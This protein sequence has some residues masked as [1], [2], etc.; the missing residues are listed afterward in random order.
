MNSSSV[1]SEKSLKN[2]GKI[3]VIIGVTGHRR[4]REQ[5]LE[6]ITESVREQI[7][8]LRRRCPHSQ[9]IVM[10]CLAEGADQLCAEIALD[11][12]L[13]IMSVLPMPIEEYAKDFTGE[14]LDKLYE[15]AEKSLKTFVAPHIEPEQEG[16]NYLYRQAGVYVAD[17]CHLLLALW[18]GS[19]PVKG[20]CGTSSIAQLK[21][22]NLSREAGEQLRHAKG[23]VVQIKTP[24]VGSPGSVEGAGAVTV[25]GDETWF[26]RV[27]R[28][29]DIYN[30]DCEQEKPA[31]S[32][33]KLSAVYE[34]ADRMSM[35]S[36]VR[37]R[38][39]LAGMSVCAVV[40][41][42]AFLL[43][44]EVDW[45]GMIILCGIMIIMLFLI[46]TITGKSKCRERYLEYRI[47][48]EAC[49]VQSYLKMAGTTLSVAEFIPWNLQV[50]VPWI[51]RAMAAVTAGDTA[52]KRQSVLKI[53]ITDQKEYHK[54]AVLRSETQ[55]MR[56]DRIVRA[57]LIFTILIYVGALAFEI[58][59]G[60]LFGGK[61]MFSAE[62]NDV[63]R[64]IIKVA[65]GTFS[66][67]TVFTGNYYGKLALPNVIDDHLKMILLYEEAE[68]EIAEKGESEPLL[69]RIAEDELGE[70]ANWYA[71]QSKYEPDLGI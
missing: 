7:G 24:P 21:L 13:E 2:K 41:A 58:I 12:G 38:K 16:R 5:D 51:S 35:V 65:M 23:Q 43:Y 11:M 25:Y 61:V 39:I 15:L 44:D 55:L 18:D 50:A 19:E 30:A 48:A 26:R 32:K 47:L 29:T 36:A 64:V 67:A 27:L 17:H 31:E 66:A 22:E 49:R 62:T 6:K 46:N 56:N 71:Y 33:E 10:T 53:W 3:P 57:A 59:C 70:N 63:I 52:G 28:D 1:Q 42:M 9:I 69:V 4:M 40:L 20:G 37:Y 54:K 34:L 68:R 8:K 60:G 45:Y 14:P